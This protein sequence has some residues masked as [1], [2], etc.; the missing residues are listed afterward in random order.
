[1]NKGSWKFLLPAGAVAVSMLSFGLAVQPVLAAETAITNWED[2][3]AVAAAMPWTAEEMR[4]AKPYPMPKGGATVTEADAFDATLGVSGTPGFGAGALPGAAGTVAP[5]MLAQQPAEE[6]L[7]PVA[8]GYTYPA[9]FTRIP[10]AAIASYLTYPFRTVGK[11]FF[12]QYGVSYVCSA[13]TVAN[14]GIVT[15][16]HCVHKGNNLATGWSTNFVFVPAYKDGA[17]PYGQW[18]IST[19]RTFTD[20]YANGTKGDFDHDWGAGRTSALRNGLTIGQTVGYLGYAYNYSRNQHWWQIG[21]PQ[22]A[23][24]DGSK[25]WACNASYAYNSPFYSGGPAPMAVGCDMTGGC[26]G[27]PWVMKFGISNYVNGVNSH[28]AT[29]HPLELSS[30]YADTDTYNSIFAWTRLP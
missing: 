11:V 30:P 2:G 3:V 27:G 6:A 16:G 26:S 1:M 22:T 9:P 18:A 14:K 23:P 10:I 29:A 13:A 21:Y 24:F 5:L 15:A 19:L 25:M 4:A 17:A 8:Q 28:R 7:G 12:K 20:W